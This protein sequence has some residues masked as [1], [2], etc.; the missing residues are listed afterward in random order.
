[1]IQKILIITGGHIDE[2]FLK[3]LIKKKDILL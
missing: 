3:S 2:N 1:M